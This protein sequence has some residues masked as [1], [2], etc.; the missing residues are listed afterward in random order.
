M[1]GSWSFETKSGKYLSVLSDIKYVTLSPSWGSFERFYME[2]KE[3]Y[4]YIQ[5]GIIY[6]N[7]WTIEGQNVLIEMD[8]ATRWVMEMWPEKAVGWN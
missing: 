6:R 4:V 8:R 1:D 3:D 5:S 7:F 2:R